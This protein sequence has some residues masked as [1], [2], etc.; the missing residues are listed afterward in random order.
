M[1]IIGIDPG[2]SGGIATIGVEGASV[3][4]MPTIEGDGI[5]GRALATLLREEQPDHVWI[6]KAQAMM[7]KGQTGGVVQQFN[8]GCGYGLIRGILMALGIPFTEVRP[9]TW[10]KIM[11][12]G[13]DKSEKA[14][15]IKRALQL[16]PMVDFKR[17]ER[18]KNY[19]DGMAEAMLIAECGRRSMGRQY[20]EAV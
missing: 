18:C 16:F 19:H 4:I 1:K 14:S 3:R 10:K 6:E 11:L 8:Y 20:A 12:D 2:M 7:R 13:M 9:Q 5:D 17:T 15:S